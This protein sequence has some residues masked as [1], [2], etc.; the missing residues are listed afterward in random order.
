[1]REPSWQ[2]LYSNLCPL[3]SQIGN[4][5]ILWNDLIMNLRTINNKMQ[6]LSVC[7]SDFLS[8]CM[9]VCMHVRM[10][11]CMYVCTYVR[12][13]ARMYVCTHAR[14][15]VRTYVWTYRTKTAGTVHTYI[16]VYISIYKYV[17]IYTK[18]SIDTH[19]LCSMVHLCTWGAVFLTIF[20]PGN[21]SCSS[22]RKGTRGAAVQPPFFRHRP[23]R[24][25]LSW[26]HLSGNGAS[27]ASPILM[28]C[29]R[30]IYPLD[31]T[32]INIWSTF[33]LI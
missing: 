17:Y 1:M 4:G 30:M 2:S 19:Y 28:H 5:V 21:R 8:V 33:G 24:P 7:L 18:V 23:Q 31:P 22:H 3:V 15:Y 32:A 10:Y 12:M 13:Y 6:W 25:G 27:L 9:Y 20:P 26:R 14:T 11:A 29:K 16:Y